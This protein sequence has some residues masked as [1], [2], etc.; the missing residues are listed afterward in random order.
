[1]P[2]PRVRPATPD[3]LGLLVSHRRRMFEE[4][5]EGS[6][7]DLDAADPVYRRWARRK[8]R[9]GEMAAFVAEVGGARVASGCVWLQPVQPRPGHPEGRQPYL[10]S[11]FTE[12]AH[13]GK[14]IAARIVKEAMRWSRARGFAR[15][16][17][18]AAPM[19][20]RVYRALGF[21][22]TWEMKAKLS[23]RSSPAST[24]RSGSRSGSRT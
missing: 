2:R 18:H 17:L 23:R 14:G 3:D 4:M 10:L 16:A 5:G 21:A 19:G 12:P 20:R 1:M 11:M 15:M 24:T 6:R 8:L 7:A 13:R 9:S 22:R